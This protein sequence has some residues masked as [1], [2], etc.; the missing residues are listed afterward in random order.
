MV[1][2]GANGKWIAPLLMHML[3]IIRSAGMVLCQLEIPMD[4][5]AYTLAVCA[6]AGVPVMLDPA[7]AAALPDAVMEADCLVHSKRN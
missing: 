7:P 4:T 2:P 6:E 1:V 5:L 3:A